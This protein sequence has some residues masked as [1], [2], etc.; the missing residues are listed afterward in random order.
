MSISN[1]SLFATTALVIAFA[2]TT[3]AGTAFAADLPV[4]APA[5]PA[6]APFFIVNDTSVSF[7]WY[8][9][10]TDPGVCN[11]SNPLSAGGTGGFCPGTDNSFSKYVG[12]ATHFDVW[13]YGTNFFNIDYIKSSDADPI[14][15][16]A[17]GVGAVEVYAFA[18]STISG[19]AVAGSKVFSNFIFKDIGFEFGGD[20]N[21]ENNYLSPEVRKLDLGAAFTF[22]LPGTVILGVLGQKE[23]NHNSFMECGVPPA[24]SF[25]FF[26]CATPGSAFNGD[27]DF[28]WAQRLELLVSEPLTFLPIPLT[29][30]SFTGVTFPKG[31]GITSAHQAAL[32]ATQWDVNTNETKTEVFEDNRLTL[33]AGKLAFG[34]AGIWETYV[35]WRYW[36]NKF[37]TDHNNGDFSNI[38]CTQ[39][40]ALGCAPGTSIENTVYL[41][42]TYHFK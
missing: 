2:A 32:G 38:G 35:G 26:G 10:G 18:R 11:P 24:G 27:R 12:S 31:S 36:Y 4:K 41:G 21:T 42:T 28:K 30:N 20:A 23:W 8:A 9:N 14:R 5:A 7:T 37:G 1:K 25:P 40:G 34:K 15:G 3:L 22:N 17:G 29:W 16:I 13:A 19:N 39:I 6:P 33:D